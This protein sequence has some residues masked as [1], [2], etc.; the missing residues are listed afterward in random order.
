MPPPPLCSARRCWRTFIECFSKST[1]KKYRGRAVSFLSPLLS[2]SLLLPFEKTQN[3]S[4]AFIS[5]R[6][7]SAKEH[8]CISNSRTDRFPA[9]EA[10]LPATAK[11]AR[12]VTLLQTRPYIRAMAGSV[13]A[14]A[15]CCPP[16]YRLFQHRRTP[17]GLLLLFLS[18]FL[19]LMYSRKKKKTPW[20]LETVN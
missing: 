13:S 10:V 9:A 14:S 1:F 4:S 2:L 20:W 16:R 15:H 5:S 8:G 6:G 19:R 17:K 11:P 7:R 12:N 18:P 3:L